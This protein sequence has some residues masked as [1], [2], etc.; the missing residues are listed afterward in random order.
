[1]VISFLITLIG[2]SIGGL[3]ALGTAWAGLKRQMHRSIARQLAYGI[4]RDL[5]SAILMSSRQSDLQKV[6]WLMDVLQESAKVNESSTV[7][8]VAGGTHFGLLDRLSVTAKSVTVY[9][10]KAAREYMSE[11]RPSLMQDDKITFESGEDL[12]DLKDALQELSFDVVVMLDIF[13]TIRPE[14]RQ[15][16][17]HQWVKRVKNDGGRLVVVI[18][19]EPLTSVSQAGVVQGVF[20]RIHVSALK[21]LLAAEG[22]AVYKTSRFPSEHRVAIVARRG[23]SSIEE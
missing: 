22:M 19:E 16:A 6:Q 12:V 21:A 18:E 2:G 9:D 20:H 13:H 3:L 1:M 15:E 23:Q 11:K 5:S 7:L 8:D 10:G 17:V 14:K 4:P